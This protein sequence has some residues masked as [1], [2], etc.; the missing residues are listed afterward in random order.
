MLLGLFTL[1]ISPLPW[2]DEVD[3]T[4]ITYSY[5]H[6]KTFTCAANDLYFPV[7]GKEVLYYGPVYF[8]LNGAIVKLFG[9]G[10]VQARLLNFLAGI[11]CVF[12]FI[13]LFERLSG[14][15][16]T[17]ANKAM[18][19]LL[20]LSDY[21]FLQDMHSGRMD[22]LALM[23]VLAGLVQ[24]HTAAQR[25]W[26]RF[27]LSGVLIAVGLLTSPRV[28]FLAVP[29]YSYLLY[30]YFKTG[31]KELLG[32][33]ACAACAACV[34]YLGWI[35][36]KLG[37]IKGYMDYINAPATVFDNA[38]G[39]FFMP[40]TNIMAH[41]WV[42]YALLFL[43]LALAVWKNR[44]LLVR[45]EVS[46]G[47]ATIV[48]FLLLGGGSVIYMSLISGFIYMVAMNLGS[49]LTVWGNRVIVLLLIINL[50]L[51]GYKYFVVLRNYNGRSPQKLGSWMHTLISPG[52]RVVAD[53]KYY[54]AVIGNGGQFQYY[55]RG[56]TENERITYHTDTWKA[57]Y[58][59]VEDT[60]TNLFRAYRNY[61]KL[62]L[63][64]EYKPT[65]MQACPGGYTSS[66]QGFLFGFK[67]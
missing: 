61:A 24:A 7:K 57:D 16:W 12:L 31:R 5:T 63:L 51:A 55:T 45:P 13:K 26:L 48:L 32:G 49:R 25:I 4:S 38:A 29:Y 36:L 33:I 46:T 64:G 39:G 6:N 3:F 58:L 52:A 42:A 41:Q 47:L 53:D 67:R 22:L 19:A 44:A 66:Y 11:V 37:G 43:L 2:Y 14:E 40:N 28:Y 27:L 30:L 34:L 54:Y 8:V 9:F 56:G 60:A 21:T 15:T 35:E 20:L 50:G 18:F 62:Q 23:F 65:G 10:I 59:L 1:K 17:A